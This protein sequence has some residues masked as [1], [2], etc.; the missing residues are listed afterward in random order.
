MRFWLFS[1]IY[2]IY[3]YFD[4][5]LFYLMIFLAISIITSLFLL[6]FFKKE[7]RVKFNEKTQVRVFENDE[8]I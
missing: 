8:Q 6:L 4:E 5:L 7:K 3:M 2:I 1:L